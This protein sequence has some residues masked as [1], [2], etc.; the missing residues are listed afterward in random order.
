MVNNI[1]FQYYVQGTN[2]LKGIIVNLPKPDEI[3]LN[4]KCFSAMKNLEFFINHNASLSG[5]TVDYFSNKLRVIHWGNCQLQYLP[6]SFQPKDLVLFSMPC[7]RIKQLGDGCK[8][9]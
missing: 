7:S 6:S 3:P 2:T 4:A 8:V 9:L 5:D 1:A